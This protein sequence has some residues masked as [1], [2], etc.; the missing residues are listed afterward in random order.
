MQLPSRGVRQAL[1]PVGTSADVTLD[2][3]THPAVV[4]CDVLRVDPDAGHAVLRFTQLAAEDGDRIER[5][6]LGL[7]V[8]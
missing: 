8:S 1:P 5:H 3:A 4:T 2:L 7:L 6:V